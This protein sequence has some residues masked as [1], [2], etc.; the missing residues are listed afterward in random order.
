MSFNSSRPFYIK[1]LS[2]VISALAFSLAASWITF[3][4][5]GERLSNV[6]YHSFSGLFAFNFIPAFFIF[7]VLG[8][9][10]SPLIDRILVKLYSLT[11]IE[12]F[13]RVVLA[14]L[15]LGIMSGII[16]SLFFFRL[17]FILFYI[18]VSILCSMVFLLVQTMLQFFIRKLT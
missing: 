2:A 8:V 5:A 11:G 7:I 4:L 18:S 9:I 1:L 10:I 12:G 6:E 15:F 16:V 13:V 3:T 14:Y 17:D